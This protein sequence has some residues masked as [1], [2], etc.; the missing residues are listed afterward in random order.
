MQGKISNEIA[1]VLT[2]KFLQDKRDRESAEG[3]FIL[4]VTATSKPMKVKGCGDR[5]C[6]C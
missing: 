1:N 6:W 3:G 2:Q 5:N 4:P